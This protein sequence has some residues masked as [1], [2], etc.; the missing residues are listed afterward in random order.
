MKKFQGSLINILIGIS[1]IYRFA[2]P[3]GAATNIS[4]SPGTFSTCPR[5]A[6]DFRAAIHVV[7]VEMYSEVRG[8]C[9]YS[10]SGDGGLTWLAPVN[11]SKNSNVFANGE[12][13]CDLDVDGAGRVSVVWIESNLI[14]MAQFF[15]Q[16]WH[17]PILVGAAR[18]NMNTPKI[19]ARPQGDLYIAWWTEDGVVHSRSKVGGAWDDIRAVSLHGVRSKF[20]DIA[21]GS[22]YAHL[23]WMQG[24]GG[25]YRVVYAWRKTAAGSAW[26]APGLLPSTGNEE[27]HPIV[28]A[29]ANDTPHIIWSPELTAG[30]VRYIAYTRATAGGFTAPERVS[31]DNIIHYPSLAMRGQD[32][33]ACWQV[34]SYRA[35]RAIGF[36]S[37]TGGAW[38]GEVLLPH[39]TASTFSDISAD[40]SGHNVYVVW[41]ATNDIY[42]ARAVESTHNDP[43]VADFS[44]TPAS[45]DFPLMVALDAS[46]SHDPDGQI[47]GFDWALGDG[48]TAEGKIVHH[49][50][51]RKGQ[52]TIRLTVRDNRGEKGTATRIV[53]VFKPNIPPEAQFTLTPKTGVV[54]LE[55]TFDASGSRDGDGRIAIYNW[56]FGDGALG[57]GIVV[58]HSYRKAGIFQV[59]LSV[60]DDRSGEGRASRSI[61]VLKPNHPPLAEFAFTPASGF[62]PLDVEFDASASR[63]PDGLIDAYQWDFGDGAAAEGRVVHHAFNT[64]GSYK[65]RLTVRDDRNGRADK[66][67]VLAV[68]SLLAP[69]NIRWKTTA[70]RALFYTRYITDVRWDRNP[71]ND[72][73]ATIV[74]YR[75]YRKRTLEP[76]STYRPIA[77]VSAAV[78]FYRDVDVGGIGLYVYTVTAVDGV[79]HESPID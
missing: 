32:L 26:S 14:K 31:S 15:D 54:P 52:F 38:K 48:T 61:E 3:A 4:N 50:Y 33:Y 16:A 56:T 51:S 77:D 6:V 18:V 42:F 40:P 35:G 44:L 72:A 67:S 36:N 59:G 65:V 5:I 58:Q 19:A 55:V 27:Q 24:S 28:V 10:R 71:G 66:E 78:S 25:G 74:K 63:D 46:A 41:D 2:L 60:V 39:S 12:R 1:I 22:Q 17:V 21:V 43:P 29:D 8:D 11:L 49:T 69:L 37:R 47:S 62:P 30:G 20:P 13:T 79:G 73:I 76:A 75:I 45:G 70:D 68:L 34:G 64:K 53:E 57:S 23:T 9:F 7:W